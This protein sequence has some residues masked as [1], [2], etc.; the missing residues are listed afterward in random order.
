MSFNPV[1]TIT[2]MLPDDGLLLQSILIEVGLTNFLIAKY[3]N[4]II[5][6]NTNPITLISFNKKILMYNF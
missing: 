5:I 3:N 6:G 1:D 2:E 4:L